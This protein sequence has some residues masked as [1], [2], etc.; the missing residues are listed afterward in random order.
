MHTAQMKHNYSLYIY[1]VQ[2]KYNY[3]CMKYE[4]NPR[5]KSTFKDKSLIISAIEAITP[6]TLKYLYP[7]SNLKK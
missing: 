3:T 1:T 7:S 6:V 5:M 4:F 2:I